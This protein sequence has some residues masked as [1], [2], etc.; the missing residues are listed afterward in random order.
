MTACAETVH[1]SFLC[2]SLHSYGLDANSTELDSG[3]SS[4][5]TSLPEDIGTHAA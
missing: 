1:F 3:A 4:T 2:S 5:K